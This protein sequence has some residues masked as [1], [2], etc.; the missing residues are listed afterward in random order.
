MQQA[1]GL[2]SPSTLNSRSPFS[3]RRG[4]SDIDAL[5]A[6]L[7]PSPFSRNPLQTPPGFR[8]HLPMSQASSISLQS[9][10]LPSVVRQPSQNTIGLAAG[11]FANQRSLAQASLPPQF[12]RSLS[13][14]ASNLPASWENSR[15]VG[16]DRWRSMTGGT[17]SPLQRSDG[18]PE[19][20]SEQNWR[21][22][23]RMRGSLTGSDY[24]A[25]IS[26]Y[27]PPLNQTATGRPSSSL[28]NSDQFSALIANNLLS[29]GVLNHQINPSQDN[30]STQQGD[31]R[32]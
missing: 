17:P 31:T 21:P 16:T 29:H 20:P 4:P 18:L 2:P 1:V 28:S 5:R 23:G 3:H 8:T 14:S 24:S 25:V 15:V 27:M 6:S 19:L 13:T 22:I 9:P 32:I 7:Q 12:S 11:N 10:S 26:N 30:F